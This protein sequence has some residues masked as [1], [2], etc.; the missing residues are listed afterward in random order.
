VDGTPEAEAS[1]LAEATSR[2]AS[3]A[4][5]VVS[6]PERQLSQRYRRLATLA[7]IP[8]VLLLHEVAGLDVPAVALDEGQCMQ[9]VTRHMLGL[10]HQRV[11]YAGVDPALVEGQKRYWGFANTLWEHGLE[12]P[13][14]WVFAGSLASESEKPRFT[15]AFTDPD[16]PTALICASDIQAAEAMA[17]L[18]ELGLSCPRDVAIAGL[19]DYEMCLWLPTP[20][21]S[22]RFDL[23][24]LARAASMMVVDIL[25]GKSVESVRISGQLIIRQSCG[26]NATAARAL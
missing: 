1:A 10:G 8:L 23:D 18:R 14:N 7:E 12:L 20:L 5:V 3:A 4:L 22:F 25:A 24:N 21:T 6:G 17:Q 26:A 16:R 19:G 2:G 13:F 9:E 15:K 11:A